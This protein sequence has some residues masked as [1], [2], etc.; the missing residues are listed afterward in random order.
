MDTE[1]FDQVDATWIE[2]DLDIDGSNSIPPVDVDQRR[3]G[4]PASDHDSWLSKSP[5][6]AIPILVSIV[7]GIERVAMLAVMP[8]NPDIPVILF[9]A[10]FVATFAVV[11]ALGGLAIQK[12]RR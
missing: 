1:N 12:H 7:F 9:G 4:R 11:L 6:W 8:G 10:L 3:R 2:A 5:W